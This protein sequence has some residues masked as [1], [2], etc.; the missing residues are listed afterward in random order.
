MYGA[1]TAY[2]Q[3]EVGR[4]PKMYGIFKR[5]GG[6]MKQDIA[7]PRYDCMF[8]HLSAMSRFLLLERLSISWTICWDSNKE[9]IDKLAIDL[10]MLQEIATHGIQYIPQ[11]LH[12]VVLWYA[13]LPLMYRT[14]V[15]NVDY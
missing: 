12:K 3:C 1:D 15:I 2:R 14:L 4:L 6:W 8:I 9:V 10:K 11:S 13:L 7:I 5:A